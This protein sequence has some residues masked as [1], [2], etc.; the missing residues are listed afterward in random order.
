M[1]AFGIV[2]TAS[3]TPAGPV[4]YM[5]V[6]DKSRPILFFVAAPRDHVELARKDN[7]RVIVNRGG[8]QRWA[9]MTF[10]ALEDGE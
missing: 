3:E 10:Q 8:I 1:S 4:Q 9:E 2:E 6:T 5:D 7:G